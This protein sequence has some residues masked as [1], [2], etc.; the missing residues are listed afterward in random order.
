VFNVQYKLPYQVRK[1][2]FKRKKYSSLIRQEC[3]QKF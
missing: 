1:V 3:K 2:N